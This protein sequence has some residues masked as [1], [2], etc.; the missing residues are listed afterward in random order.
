MSFLDTPW[1]AVPFPSAQRPLVQRFAI[2]KDSPAFSTAYLMMMQ[3]RR[4]LKQ[5]YLMR[6]DL[7]LAKA[8]LPQR[9]GPMELLQLPPALSTEILKPA[10][11]IL[12]HV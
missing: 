10:H 5:L 2:P 9:K 12:G 3:P 1:Y 7:L 4:T 11:T 6:Q 8:F